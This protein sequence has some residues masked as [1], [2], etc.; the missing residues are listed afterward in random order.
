MRPIH[1]M[2]LDKPGPVLPLK[3]KLQT[4]SATLHSQLRDPGPGQVPIPSWP[5]QFSPKAKARPLPRVRVYGCG[6]RRGRL[7]I[8]I[9]QYPEEGIY[10][11][12]HKLRS[13]R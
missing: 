2:F 9:L 3:A 8:E 6:A 12:S 4:Q 13:I 1:S 11:N 7:M 5:L 10:N